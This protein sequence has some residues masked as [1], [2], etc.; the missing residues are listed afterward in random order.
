MDGSSDRR[1]LFARLG[2]CLVGVIQSPFLLDSMPDD[3]SKRSW[4]F[5]GEM[6]AMVSVGIIIVVGF[7]KINP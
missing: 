4:P 6:W 1:W 3:F 2:L 7:Q 5:F